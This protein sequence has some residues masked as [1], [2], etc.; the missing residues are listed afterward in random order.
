[1]SAGFKVGEI[2]I[3]QNF[4]DARWRNGM[5]CVVMSPFFLVALGFSDGTSETCYA[6]RVQWTDGDFGRQPA[7]RLRRHKPPAADSNERMHMQQWRDMAGKAVQ[8]V[9][10]MA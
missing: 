10:E 6:C 8:P 9:G 3:G 2:L 4:V 5:E 1:M 7:R